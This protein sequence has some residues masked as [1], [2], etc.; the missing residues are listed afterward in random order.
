MKT[1]S[2]AKAP[3]I[4][5]RCGTA[6]AVPFQRLYELR[7]NAGTSRIKVLGFCCCRCPT[8]RK[9]KWGTRQFCLLMSNFRK[10]GNTSAILRRSDY[11]LLDGSFDG[12]LLAKSEGGFSSRNTKPRNLRFACFLLMIS[13]RH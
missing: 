12:H 5:D 13:E 6:E 11:E 7:G 4:W 2:G 8:L 3:F 9:R 1:P 10:P